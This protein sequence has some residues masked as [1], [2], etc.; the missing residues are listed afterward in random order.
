MG[1]VVYNKQCEIKLPPELE[2][3]L[4]PQ[5]IAL[6]RAKKGKCK[7]KVKLLLCLI[8]HHDMKKSRH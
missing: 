5:S 4:T 7:A 1:D 2:A 3:P 8:K 6:G